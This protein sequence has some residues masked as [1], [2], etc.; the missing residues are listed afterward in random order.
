MNDTERILMNIAIETSG[1]C[2][3]EMKII[4]GRWQIRTSFNKPTP[5]FLPLELCKLIEMPLECGDIIRCE[6]NRSHKWS[7][8]KLVEIG[9]EAWICQQIG[10]KDIVK[11][12]NE[13]ISVLRF[14]PKR[15]LLQGK[16][17]KIY[18]WCYKAFLPRYNDKA[19]YY[20]RC[21]GVEIKP[22]VAIVWS[23][24][25]IFDQE[26]LSKNKETLY[27]VPRRFEISWNQKTRLKDIVK[28]IKAQGF[29]KDYEYNTTR[30]TQ[31]MGGCCTFTKENIQTALGL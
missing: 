12:Y 14:M 22:N 26:K 3:N 2:H 23:R 5:Q 8:S 30:P 10:G 13:R 16:E 27:A 15:L 1:N 19:N 11:I 6:T 25:H 18:D 21:G 24:P 31:G 29:D 9:E 7:I 20:K 17:K 28:D 4:I